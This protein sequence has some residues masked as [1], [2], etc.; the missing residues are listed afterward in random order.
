MK[1]LDDIGYH[2]WTTI[3]KPGGDTKEGLKDLCDRL[4]KIHNC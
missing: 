2:G 1:S 3:E 4:V